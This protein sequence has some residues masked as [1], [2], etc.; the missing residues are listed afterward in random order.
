[1]QSHRESRR[2][3]IST[4]SLY[5]CTPVVRLTFHKDHNR[6]NAHFLKEKG[7]RN[8]L[9]F[10]RTTIPRRK[11][12]GK[13]QNRWHVLSRESSERS[14]HDKCE[15]RRRLKKRLQKTNKKLHQH[16][17]TAL[18]RVFSHLTIPPFFSSSIDYLP[19]LRQSRSFEPVHALLKFPQSSTNSSTASSPFLLAL[20]RVAVGSSVKQIGEQCWERVENC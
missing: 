3:R 12:D 2:Q 20:R 8:R 6:S 4:I 1:M 16:I 11:K 9:Q 19:S 7:N 18:Q 13:A 15:S 17:A 14:P 5:R 10:F